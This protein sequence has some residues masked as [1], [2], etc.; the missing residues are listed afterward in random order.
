MKSAQPLVVN[1]VVFRREVE[2]QSFYSAILILSPVSLIFSQLKLYGSILR[3][4]LSLSHIML[5]M[6][7]I[8]SM[9]IGVPRTEYST[10]GENS[11]Y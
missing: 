11:M 1:F 8:V 7:S 6:L 4:V 5:C 3:P 10:L 2:F 9:K